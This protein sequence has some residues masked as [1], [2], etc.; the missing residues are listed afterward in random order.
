LDRLADA[1]LLFVEGAPPEAQYR[2]KHALIQDAAYDS[3]LKSRR[4]A[5]H[6][7][8]AEALVEA[9]AQPEAIANHFTQAGLDDLAIEWWG[10]AGDHALR[11]S[12]FQEAIA[13]LGKAIEMANRAGAT[14]RRG[15]EDVA[16][17]SQRMKLQSDYS[18][19]MM[20]SK[21]FAA[22]ETKAA[23]ARTAELAGKTDDFSERFIA[24][25][26][27]FVAACTGGEL[28]SA[29][30]LAMMLLLEAEDAG[31]IREAGR[32]NIWLGLIAYWHGDFVEARTHCERA[33]AARDP[34]PDPK[35][36]ELLGDQSTYASSFLAATMWQLGEVERARELIDTATR[37]ASELGHTGAIA[38][39]LFWKSY[40]EVWRGDPAATLSAAEALESVAREYTM[41]QFLNEAELHSGWARGRI[42]DPTA[43][44]A[45][46]R[47]VLA[48]FVD[49]GV[50]VNLGFY[51][52]LLA[53]LEAETLGA[54]SA[55]ARIDEALR[56]SDE[57]EHRCSLPFLHRM[58][59]E[60]LLRGDPADPVPA[61]EAFRTSIAIAKEQCARSPLL[62]ASLS[63]AK[64]YQSTARPAEAN[65]VLAPALEGFSPTPEMPEIAEAQA[66]LSR[67][68]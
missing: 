38:D 2:F 1:D 57:V 21:G 47:R 54:D 6:R 15:A 48:A 58:R 28:R 61:E 43:G 52:G 18:Q 46:I 29:R 37:R 67:L 11:R 14:A 40:L 26:G 60:I 4:Q 44:A 51:N 7:R 59:G 25:Q 62:L 35:V 63:L 27:Q 34:N 19:A 3:L 55:L 31:R 32:A 12:A 39:A 33:L 36:R 9:K 53:K 24:L 17:S 8:A 41:V 56:L 64:L 5:L 66:L 16:T 10:K 45:Q 49:Q 20:W 22:E 30:E 13:H 68:P 65:A 42:N 50:K 23:F